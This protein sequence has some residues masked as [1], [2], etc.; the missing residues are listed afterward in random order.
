MNKATRFILLAAIA[1]AFVSVNSCSL[2][3]YFSGYV[4]SWESKAPG[5]DN[6]ASGLNRFVGSVR[7]AQGNPDAH[8]LLGD[9]YQGRGRHREA[10]EEFNKSIRI[11]PQCV[12]AYNGIAVSLD[13]M[14]EHERALEY[15]QAALAIQP[16]LDYLYNNMGYSLL[17]QERYEEAAAAFEKANAI[18]GGKISRIQN[19]LALANSALGKTDPASV[20][21]DPK[22]QA[23]IEYTAGNIRL[24]NGSFEE[25]RGHYRKSLTLNPEMR[26]ARKG[27]E[28]ATLLA[29]VKRSLNEEATLV[30]D[31]KAAPAII[32]RDGIEISNGNGV[33]R[34]ARDVGNFLERQGFKV[35]RLTNAEHFKYA[36]AMVY[37]RGDAEFTALRIKGTIPGITQMKKV[38]GFERDN[39]QVKVIVGKDL[40]AERDTFKK[41]EK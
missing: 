22:H 16:E 17:Q 6:M 28:V 3:N 1:V 9:Y 34:M 40:A 10:V 38:S 14:G 5:K 2:I 39:V 35:V 13:Q 24:K 31:G 4:K 29:D 20:P 41:G 30:L 27:E 12:K 32:G 36:K 33:P 18:S 11:D 23:L 8:Y 21:A 15:Y 7:S 37:Y 19:N 25:A 26:G